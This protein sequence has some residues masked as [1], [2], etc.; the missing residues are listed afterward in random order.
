LTN[1]LTY[2]I[3][4]FNAEAWIARCVDSLMNNGTLASSIIVVDD[5]STDGTRKVLANFPGISVLPKMNGGPSSARNFGLQAVR[6]PLVCFLDADDFVI[7]RHAEFISATWDGR[8]DAILCLSA[9]A[10]GETIKLSRQSK[11]NALAN[12]QALLRAWIDDNCLQTAQIVWRTEFARQLGGFDPNVRYWDDNDFAIRAFANNPAIQIFEQMSWVVWDRRG[13]GTSLSSSRDESYA[14]H[15]LHFNTKLFRAFSSR[16]EL[17]NSLNA[18]LVREAQCL[19]RM[20][21]KLQARKLLGMASTIGPTVITY[22]LPDRVV[23]WLA[24][25]ELAV[26]LR[27]LAQRLKT[28]SG[29]CGMRSF[30]GSA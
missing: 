8:S 5:G 26:R 23:S 4:A 3:P 19:F 11:Y 25:V 12:P 18:R 9:E 7:G 20:N 10:D 15:C 27:L 14:R 22:P 6:S 17:A 21:F 1:L 30:R 2:V 28:W 16:P 24:G 13:E 29:P